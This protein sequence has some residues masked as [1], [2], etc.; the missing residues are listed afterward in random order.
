MLSKTRMTTILPVANL[1]RARRFYGEALGLEALGQSGD[2]KPL[3][4]CASGMI[5]LMER[6]PATPAAHTAAS[7]EVADIGKA[8]AQLSTQGVTFEDYDLPGLKTVDKVCVLGAEK[9]AWF[10]DP[11]GNILCLHE[12]LKA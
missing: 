6:S 1:E 11:D 3:F 5:G 10:K 8:I 4:G 12:S 7:F 2:G 9:A